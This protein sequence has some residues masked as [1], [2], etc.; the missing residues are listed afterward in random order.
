ML[1]SG[2]IAFDVDLLSRYRDLS[3]KAAQARVAVFVV[4]L[5]QPAYDASDRMVETV[6]SGREFTTGLG[7]IASL[8]GGV[9]FGPSVPLPAP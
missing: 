1:F 9:F 8:T 3:T 5:D 4:H 7:N 2:G 6:F